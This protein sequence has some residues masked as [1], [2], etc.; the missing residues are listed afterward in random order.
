VRQ[1]YD[2][3]DAEARDDELQKTLDTVF[4]ET[5]TPH[6]AVERIMQSLQ[7]RKASQEPGEA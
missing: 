7:S 5:D 4:H 1:T 6:P 2:A 3:A